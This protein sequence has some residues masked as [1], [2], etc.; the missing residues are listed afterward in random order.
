[1]SDNLGCVVVCAIVII[2]SAGA[3]PDLLKLIEHLT[4][5][6]AALIGVLSVVL[7]GFY[8]VKKKYD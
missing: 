4:W 2:A 8:W 6:H 7:L 5:V 3:L 1:M